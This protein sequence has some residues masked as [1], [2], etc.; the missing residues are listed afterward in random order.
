M[1]DAVNMVYYKVF[2]MTAEMHRENWGNEESEWDEEIITLD[3]IKEWG[4]ESY[5]LDSSDSTGD[6]GLINETIKSGVVCLSQEINLKEES[7]FRIYYT[8]DSKNEDISIG[9]L[10]PAGVIR[11]II[12]SEYINYDF[13]IT[14]TGKYKIYVYNNSGED[15]NIF[16]SYAY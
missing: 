1:S 11:Y 13:N 6:A 15:V 5:E 3:E 7:I 4:I 12:C 10:Q 8:I 14:Q 9:I 16:I 2:M